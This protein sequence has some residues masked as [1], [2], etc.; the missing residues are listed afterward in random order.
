MANIPKSRAHFTEWLMSNGYTVHVCAV[1][2]KLPLCLKCILQVKSKL[3][4]LPEFPL[5]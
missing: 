2:G 4:D 3:N 1:S 5:R